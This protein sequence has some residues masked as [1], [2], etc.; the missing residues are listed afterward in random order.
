MVR[1]DTFLLG[2]VGA[3][4]TTVSATDL[5]K[6]NVWWHTCSYETYLSPVATCF[7]FRTLY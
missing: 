3:L 1:V 6:G 4:T 5:S 2:L 7:C